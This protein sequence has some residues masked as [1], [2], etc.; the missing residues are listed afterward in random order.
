LA[1]SKS[2]QKLLVSAAVFTIL[3]LIF[4]CIFF[5]R[6]AT[7]KKKPIEITSNKRQVGFTESSVAPTTPIHTHNDDDDDD[8]TYLSPKKTPTKHTGLS[9]AE[10][11]AFAL[12]TGG[13]VLIKHGRMGTRHIRFVTISED[14]THICWRPIGALD[15]TN[16]LPLNSFKTYVIYVSIQ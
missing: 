2:E 9:D 13:T 1:A 16:A 7:P 14:L 6:N 10:E 3:A 15:K 4:T 8:I 12:I 11:T 5:S